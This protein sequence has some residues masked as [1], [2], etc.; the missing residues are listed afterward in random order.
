MMLLTKSMQLW[1]LP[2]ILLSYLRI[3]RASVWKETRVEVHGISS[4]F[5]LCGFWKNLVSLFKEP[6]VLKI[7]HK[8]RKGLV[9]PV[10][11]AT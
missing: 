10:Q 7:R 11:Y 1:A 6:P 4:N 9:S 2:P 3:S 8:S 5:L